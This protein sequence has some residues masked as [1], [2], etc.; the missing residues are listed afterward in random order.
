MQEWIEH[1]VDE[2]AH[3][4]SITET[5]LTDRNAIG[6]MNSIYKIYTSNFT[7]YT[8]RQHAASLGTALLV[9]EKLQPHIHDIKTIPGTAICIDF[10]F[11]KNNKMRIISVYLPTNHKQLCER[12]QT[13][14]FEWYL[15][16]KH[17]NW[18]IIILGDF[19]ANLNRDKKFPLFVNL[20]NANATSLLDFHNITS[21]TWIG[22]SAQSQIDDIWC[23]QELLLDLEKPIITDAEYITNSDHRI[24]STRWDT[25]LQ[26]SRGPRNKRRKR[27][28]FQYEKIDSK[29]WGNSHQ[30]SYQNLINGQ[31]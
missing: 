8:D 30:K 24:I 27:K 25:E 12:T 4:I 28:I 11:P 1:C 31:I 16:A 17:H 5:K 14:V 18:N 26:T 6:L 19:N 23:N 9:Y 10:F 15:E 29:K 20:S 22:P 7:P 2:N 21:P 3:I 13:K